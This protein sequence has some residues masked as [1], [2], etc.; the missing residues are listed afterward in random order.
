MK[1]VILFIIF[2]LNYSVIFSQV[3][4]TNNSDKSF[5]NL[6]GTHAINMNIGFK[7]NSN[8]KTIAT[9]GEVK[10]ETNFIG[11]IG[12]QYWFNN[13]WT[14]NAS[15]GLF[16]AE[17]DIKYTNVTSIDI[18]PVLFG[19]SYYPETFSLGDVGRIHFGINAGVYRAHG[20]KAGVDLNNIW[21]A[22]TTSVEE[23]VFG[24]E[25]NVGIDFFVS[26]WVKIGPA[27]SYHFLGDFD[28]VIGNRKNYSGPVFSII[29]GLLL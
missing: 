26:K 14:V 23:T 1:S 11:M 6:S 20:T 4:A 21:N 10:A 5:R 24:V 18:S 7:V 25:P 15:V 13:E 8:N 9:V 17:A 12:Y 28:E 29:A 3:D 22:G 19:I 2:L 27:I 16:Q